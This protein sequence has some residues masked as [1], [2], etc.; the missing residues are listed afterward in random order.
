MNSDREKVIKT[1]SLQKC[2][3]CNESF[4]D[5]IGGAVV[6]A[7]CRL[8]GLNQ[9]VSLSTSLCERC[10]EKKESSQDRSRYCLLCYGMLSVWIKTSLKHI[11]RLSTQLY[12]SVQDVRFVVPMLTEAARM[13]CG[14]EVQRVLSMR[15]DL[16][17]LRRDISLFQDEMMS[18]VKRGLGVT[19]MNIK[20]YKRCL[21]CVAPDGEPSGL[22]RIVG[23]VTRMPTFPIMVSEYASI[24]SEGC[25]QDNFH[26]SYQLLHKQLRAVVAQSPVVRYL[27][28]R[29]QMSRRLKLLFYNDNHVNV[30]FEDS[31]YLYF[32]FLPKRGERQHG[33]IGRD[34]PVGGMTACEMMAVMVHTIHASYMWDG[35]NIVPRLSPKPIL[36]ALLTTMNM[37]AGYRKFVASNMPSYIATIGTSGDTIV[38]YNIVPKKGCDSSTISISACSHVLTM[39]NTEAYPVE[40]SYW[41]GE[42][43]SSSQT[44]GP[45]IRLVP[46]QQMNINF[47]GVTVKKIQYYFQFSMIHHFVNGIL[48][49][50]KSSGLV[51]V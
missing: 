33:F 40:I 5:C 43:N 32:S 48:A 27:A 29:S 17:S 14:T 21:G 20:N 16:Q 37:V 8:Q 31:T 34:T 38:S 46:R 41:F 1:L 24:N 47:T 10:E 28:Y 23:M 45:K 9:I 22:K 15:A 49:Y 42:E 4:A 18:P 2:V 39:I 11:E 7:Y 12:D 50:S 44:K 6:C 25:G 19:K 35:D 3:I 13:I 26:N 30:R 36:K 51:A